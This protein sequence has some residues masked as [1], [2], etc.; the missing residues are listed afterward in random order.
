MSTSRPSGCCRWR[1]RCSSHL[2]RGLLRRAGVPPCAG[3]AMRRRARQVLAGQRVGFAATCSNVPCAI[4]RPPCTPAPGPMSITWSAA[5]IMSSSCSTTSTL[6]PRSR[7]CAGCRSGGRCR[8]GAG[9][10][11][12]RPARTSRR[13]GPSRSGWP[14]GCA[15]LAAAERLGAAVQAQVVQAHVV[16]ELQPQADL[17]HHLVGDL[18]LGAVQLQRGRSRPAP[19]QRGV[20]D[21]VDGARL[22]RPRRSSRGAPRAQARAGAVRAGL[23]AAVARQFLAHRHRVGLAV[24]PLHVGD[25]ALERVL[26]R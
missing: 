11:W 13:S 23:Q 14:G 10:C 17:A 26:A 21:L 2:G 20:A 6:L 4:T 22:G 9:R 16:Q 8:A 19:R 18:G 7:R 15:G 25:D 1:P 3:T 24:A 12:A 5:R